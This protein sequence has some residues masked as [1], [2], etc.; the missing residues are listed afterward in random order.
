MFYV[1][2]VLV[3]GLIA[4]DVIKQGLDSAVDTATEFFKQYTFIGTI[5]RVQTSEGILVWENGDLVWD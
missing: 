1:Q 5:V 4:R 2:V 3:N